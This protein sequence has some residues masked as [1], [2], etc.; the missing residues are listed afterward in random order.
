MALR[1][2]I[3]VLDIERRLSEPINTF[4][5]RQ[6]DKGFSVEVNL[7]D[8]GVPLDMEGKDAYLMCTTAQ[9]LIAKQMLVNG[10]VASVELGTDATASYGAISPYVEIRIGE[11]VVAATNSFSIQI[12]PAADLTAPEAEAKQSRLDVV[13]DHWNTFNAEADAQ[14]EARKTTEQAR[15][16]AESTRISNEQNRQ[17]QESIRTEQENLRVQ[18]EQARVTAENAR[19]AEE[20]VRTDSETARKDAESA[21]IQAEQ[22]REQA[23]QERVQTEQARVQAEQIRAQQQI[24]NNS[25]QAANNAAAQGITYQVLASGEYKLDSAGKHNVPTIDGQ[26]G[27]IYLTP[28][29]NPEAN[30]NFEQWLWLNSQWELAGDGV[31]IDPITTSDIKKVVDGENPV[32]ERYLNLTGLSYYNSTYSDFIFASFRASVEDLVNT[33]FPVGSYIIRSEFN[34]IV[35]DPSITKYVTDSLLGR[36]KST[37]NV[38]LPIWVRVEEEPVRTTIPERTYTA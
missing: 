3:T 26:N 5:V 14:E 31:Y 16:Q 12:T 27:K 21:R 28:T 33:I 20:N 7:L 32:G 17:S 35:Y 37:D 22:A 15:E 29:V 4:I 23:E 25:D 24:R 11:E 9:G 36:W 34:G 6:Y 13:I 8:D 30:N 10:N 19:V 18:A 1:H 2:F 38:D